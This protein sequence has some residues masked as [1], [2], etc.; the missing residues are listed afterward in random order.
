MD[1]YYTVMV[2]PEKEKGV[3]TYRVPT[4][5]FKSVAFLFVML[6]ALIG[7]LAFDYWKIL[8]QVYENKHLSIENR[9]LKEQ[10]QL[11]QMKMNSIASDLKRINTFE[12]K[13]RVITGL[14]DISK[15]GPLYQP[16]NQQDQEKFSLDDLNSSLD[17]KINQD[18]EN[19]EKFKELKSLYDK[20]IAANLGLERSYLLTKQWSELARRSFAL[21]SEYAKF[22]YKYSMLK[23]VVDGIEGRIHQLDQHLLDRESF[24][25]S[26]PTILP[27]QGW[28]TSYFGQRMSPWAG[29]V[30]MHEGLDIGAPFGTPILAAAD[31]IIT[32][33]G[34]KAGFGKFVQIDHGYGIETLYA[35]NQSLHVKAGQRVKR[36]TLVAGVGTT[37]HS[38]GPHLH[39]EVRV[40][41]IAV[42]PLY[43]ILE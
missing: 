12:K 40:N 18:V 41:G 39:Y 19:D 4:V 36:G 31:G 32:F 11:F 8:Q 3:K 2:V 27:T 30:K 33:S 43:Y 9:Q 25:N 1:K 22:D 38:T 24:L 5:L 20:K 10:I 29:R 13:L 28:I 6:M 14:E 7:V 21:S 35:H 34:E 37:G 23:E 26:T 15:K 17:L 16:T 42:D